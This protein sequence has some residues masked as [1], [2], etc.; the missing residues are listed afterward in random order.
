M[1]KLTPL[2][3]GIITGVVMVIVTLALYYSKLPAES[4]LHYII[5]ILYAMGIAWALISYS[6]SASYTGKFADIFGQ[7]FRCF[8]V[9]TL[10]MVAF[11]AIFS[12]QHPEFAEK[13]AAYYKEGLIKERNKTPAEIEKLVAD[14]RKQYTTG[15]VSLTIFGY[16]ITGAVITAA[17]SA[18]L[19][20]RRK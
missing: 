11:T 16:L 12:M 14:A 1:K 17:G 20:M 6:R 7:G 3:K 10:I 19:L 9:V 15:L 18:F 2:I 13:A 5:Y 4:N 8:I